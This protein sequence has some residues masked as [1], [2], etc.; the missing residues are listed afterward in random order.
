M[1]LVTT[2]DRPYVWKARVG[3]ITPTP[4]NEHNAYAFYP[5][6]PGGV[7][8]KIEGFDRPMREI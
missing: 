1:A 8:D 7:T 4:A 3:M 6:A 2:A 5:I